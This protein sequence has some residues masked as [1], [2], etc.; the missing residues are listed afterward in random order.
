[1]TCFSHLY[2]ITEEVGEGA[3]GKVVKCQNIENGKEMAVKIYSKDLI[4]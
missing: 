2:K 4:F 1:M 3:F